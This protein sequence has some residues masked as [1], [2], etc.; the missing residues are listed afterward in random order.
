MKVLVINSGSSS[1][2]YSLFEMKDSTSRCKGIVERIGFSNSIL[3]YQKGNSKP[4]IMKVDAPNHH[5]AIRHI[6]SSL[7]NPVSGVIKSYQEIS[8]IGH[9]VVHGAEAFRKPTLINDKVM[10]TIE[11]FSELAPLHNPPALLGITACKKFVGNIPEV[12]VFDTAFHHTISPR[13]YVYG[14]PY[15][16]YKNLKIR[17]YGFHGTSHKF[18]AQQAAKRLR[19]SLKKLKLVTCHIGS[20]ASITA[21]KNGASIDTSMGFTPLEGLL[22]GTRSGDIDPAVILFLMEKKGLNVKQMSNLLNKKSGLLGITGISNDMRDVLK[23]MKK[24][25]PRARLAFEMFLYRV[26]KYIGSYAAAMDGIDAVVLTAGIG[27]NLPLINQRIEKDLQTFLRR[28]NA[29]VLVIPTNEEL[30]IARETAQV[31]SKLK[32]R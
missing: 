32:R 6:F 1:I 9:R 23:A 20:G 30:M 26:K 2:K 21:V 10:K 16:F 25:N 13:A 28:F 31:I 24:G 8:G 3:T 15:E 27:E 19:K 29:K 4:V 22:M 14:I 11:K 17:R 7:T 5:Q 18:V 12:G